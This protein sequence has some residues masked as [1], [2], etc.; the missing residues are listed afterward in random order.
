MF[1]IHHKGHQGHQGSEHHATDARFQVRHI[2]VDD[3]AESQA[4]C[5]EIGHQMGLVEGVDIIHCSV[6]IFFVSFVSLVVDFNRQGSSG[7]N[8]QLLSTLGAPIAID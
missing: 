3:E 1:P 5:F 4:N 6:C 2:E 8:G 7:D